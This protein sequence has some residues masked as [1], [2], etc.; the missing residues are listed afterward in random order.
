MAGTAAAASAVLTVMRTSS[1]PASAS[2][3]TC[4]TVAATSAVSVLVIDCTTIGAPPPIWMPPTSTARAR[5]RVIGGRFDSLM[6]SLAVEM[7]ARANSRFYHLPHRTRFFRPRLCAG[8]TQPSSTARSMIG[9]RHDARRAP[10]T[11]RCSGTFARPLRRSLR[12]ENAHPGRSCRSPA[13]ATRAH[14]AATIESADARTHADAAPGA[15]AGRQ[16]MRS[17]WPKTSTSHSRVAVD[18]D[19][20]HGHDHA[21]ADEPR[22]RR[23]GRLAIELRRRRDLQHAA[24]RPSRRCGRRAP[25]LRPGRA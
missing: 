21:F 13:P 14:P 5:R 10:A 18:R 9:A 23:V 3:L 24:A 25:S 6:R 15:C 7:Y 17:R 20:A 4:A 12:R 11:V 19:D 1:E 16:R 22:H 8:M 2:A